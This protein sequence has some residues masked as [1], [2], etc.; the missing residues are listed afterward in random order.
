MSSAW[1]TAAK[2]AILRLAQTGRGPGRGQMTITIARRKFIAGFA[3]ATLAMPFVARAQRQ[4]MPVL[5]FIN[6]TGPDPNLGRVA[7]FRQGLRDLGYA[8]RENLL[9]QYRWAE[10]QAYKLPIMAGDL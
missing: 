5:G 3:G 7:A 4:A 1:S 9:I 2:R 10:N 8:E 6:S